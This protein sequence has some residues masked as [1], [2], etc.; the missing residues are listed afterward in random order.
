MKLT[1]IEIKNFRL[2]HDV[3]I[4]LDDNITA[5]VGKNNSGKTSLTEIFRIFLSKN[6]QFEY[7]DFSLKSNFEFCKLFQKY[8]T[9]NDPDKKEF[10]WNE[11]NMS[12]PKIQLFLT[13]QY[14]DADN[15]ENITKFLTNLDDKNEFV[16]LCEYA[17]KSTEKFLVELCSPEKKK[18]LELLQTNEYYEC[19]I[20]PY[21][22]FEETSNLS[23]SELNALI[24][25]KFI[26][27]QRAVDD[28]NSPTNSKK[29]SDVFHKQFNDQ[30][31]KASSAASEELITA[32]DTANTEIEEKLKT[33]FQTFTIKFG[34][35]GFPGLGKEGVMLKSE[36]KSDHLFKDNV[37]LFHNIDGNHL[38]EKYSGLGYSNLIYILAQLIA[39]YSEI[40]NKNALNLIFIEEPE[41]HMHPQMQMVFIQK[42]NDFLKTMGINCQI[43]FTTHSSHILSNTKLESIRYF[44]KNAY[45]SSVKDLSKLSAEP[46]QKVFLQQ[47]LTLGRCDLFFA[48][49]AILIEGVVERIL[50]PVFMK[51]I[52][53]DLTKQYI[54]TVEVGG[55]HAHLFKNL[56][57]FL[58]LKALIITDIDSVHPKSRKAC[59]TG[60]SDAK[61]CNQTIENLMHGESI[62]QALLNIKPEQKIIEIKYVQKIE[63]DSIEHVSLACLAYQTKGGRSF[64]EEF[65]LNNIEYIIKYNKQLHGI[66]P[67]VKK[68]F[69]TPELIK[70]YAYEVSHKIK[71]TDFAFDLLN[72]SQDEW[73][74]PT[75][76]EEGLL[77]LAK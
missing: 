55:A 36:L 12:I 15:W 61:S 71:K 28:S 47:Y 72:V 43:V 59:K 76:I 77:W 70:K 53:Q 69:N 46:S 30:H 45:V 40:E 75:Y 49:K 57:A 21:S 41:A 62:I 34:E 50:L 67:A 7:S 2:L 31:E 39:F 22:E 17:P 74:V 32:L 9:N 27:A 51:K 8:K 26:Y 35:F 52:D 1:S 68:N 5:I 16:V 63:N 25:S 14:D 38:P 54:T 20:R 3:K 23:I 10:L 19:K 48:D 29:L 24:N 58:E 11:L 13:V 60:E 44:I 64:E 18:S 33:F 6:K 65:I 37:R 42:I 56:L 73:K 4:K 66:K